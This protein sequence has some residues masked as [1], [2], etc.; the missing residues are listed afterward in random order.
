MKQ[1]LTPGSPLRAHYYYYRQIIY[2]LSY[3]LPDYIIANSQILLHHFLIYASTP[4]PYTIL[5][6]PL[7]HFLLLPIYLNLLIGFFASDLKIILVVGRLHPQKDPYLAIDIFNRL[8]QV[9]QSYR[10]VFIGTG[11]L[12]CSLLSYIKPRF[13]RLYIICRI[14]R[15]L[16]ILFV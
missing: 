6:N 2:S 5:P 9:D 15:Q 16:F 4:S 1:I 3:F 14:C 12:L 11:S 10:L 13:I 7:P 8:F